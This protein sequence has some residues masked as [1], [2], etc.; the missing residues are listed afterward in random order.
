MRNLVL[1]HTSLALRICI[2][3]GRRCERAVRTLYKCIRTSD[4]NASAYCSKKHKV[5]S[6]LNSSC[7]SFEV[8]LIVRSH[9]SQRYKR[10]YHILALVIE[11]IKMDTMDISF[12]ATYNHTCSPD[13]KRMCLECAIACVLPRRIILQVKQ[14]TAASQITS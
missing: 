12:P 11:N 1:P 5:P 14:N 6:I 7:C 8:V 2:C 3:A 13:L 9:I 10:D 4:F